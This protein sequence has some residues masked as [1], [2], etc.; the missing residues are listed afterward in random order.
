[1]AEMWRRKRYYAPRVIIETNDVLDSP[2]E[3]ALICLTGAQLNLL[4]NMTQYLH[5]RST[6]ASAYYGS[7]YL[8]PTNEEW[9]ALDAIVADLEN[10]LM[11]CPE[12]L[13]L[14]E[15]IRDCV[16]AEAQ[17]GEWPAGGTLPGQDDYDTYRSPVIEDEGEPPEG[18]ETWDDWKVQKCKS[19]QK[20]VDDVAD[21]MGTA[22]VVA[23]SGVLLT[24]VVIQGLIIASAIVP[25]IA[26]VLAI[27]TLLAAIGLASINEQAKLWVQAHKQSMVCIIFEAANTL[28]AASQLHSYIDAEWSVD[29]SPAIVK[30]LLNASTLSRIFDGAVAGYEG[31]EGDY[32]AAYC[33]ACQ[34]PITGSDWYARACYPLE[35]WYIERMSDGV[36]DLCFPHIDEPL[37]NIQ[38]II[39]EATMSESGFC[40][41]KTMTRQTC[42]C[43]YGSGQMF[44]DSTG[45]WGPQVVA[46][47][48]PTE[49]D[50]IECAAYFGATLYTPG[51]YAPYE[52]A[53]GA[54][55][56][57]ANQ[58]RT[59]TA[60]VTHI[61]FRGTPP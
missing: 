48:N 17:P 34:E 18:W 52:H 12:I 39:Y 13:A 35:A 53:E 49:I 40:E 45:I 20:M 2:F 29:G 46:R 37:H 36:G 19:A 61:I 56:I 42:G 51:A 41:H 21:W 55:R 23:G 11:G 4:R 38:G 28:D 58:G 15:N 59:I 33:V 60:Q 5:R 26:I 16:C 9:D 7:Y 43:S 3:D 10:K 25:P 6:F 54:L 30:W 31:W 50:E 1:M 22:T 27:A 14:L 32:S 44:A 24:F 57:Y 47:L 8:A